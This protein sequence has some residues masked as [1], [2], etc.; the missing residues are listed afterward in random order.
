VGVGVVVAVIVAVALVVVAA[1]ALAAV[2]LWLWSHDMMS[3]DVRLL[4]TGNIVTTPL[5]GVE[6]WEVRLR[7]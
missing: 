2:Q 1:V 3:R 6:G 7:T 4:F 5:S